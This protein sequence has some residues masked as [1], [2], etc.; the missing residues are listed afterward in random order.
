MAESSNASA[1]SQSTQ[2]SQF[3]QQEQQQQQQQRQQQ[4]QPQG[5]PDQDQQV[6]QHIQECHEL[7]F[8]L[9][10]TRVNLVLCRNDSLKKQAEDLLAN[11]RDLSDD[12]KFRQMSHQIQNGRTELGQLADDIVSRQYQLHG[13]HPPYEHVPYS[14]YPPPPSFARPCFPPGHPQLRLMQQQQQMLRQH[15]SRE[16]QQQQ[17]QKLE[18]K[19]EKC[20][21]L[22]MSLMN[23]SRSLVMRRNILLKKQAE[24]LLNSGADLNGSEM[25]GKL[26]EGEKELESLSLELHGFKSRLQSQKA[27]KIQLQQVHARTGTDREQGGGPRDSEGSDDYILV[28]EE[29]NF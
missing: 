25:Q 11:D 29:N 22:L 24:E 6:Q 27:L 8:G 14:P 28:K 7:K 10:E 23:T 17:E 12:I 1:L 5:Q 13:Q 4:P 18:Q 9:W 3:Q 16:Q 2:A 20:N 21:E 19:L 15:Q 26:A